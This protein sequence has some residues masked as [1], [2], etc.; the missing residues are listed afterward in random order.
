MATSTEDTESPKDWEHGIQLLTEAL[1]KV[2][3]D[4]EFDIPSDRAQKSRLC[5]HKLLQWV[6]INEVTAG[7]FVMD[8]LHSLQRCCSHPRPVKF[9]TL[10]E[11]IWENYY[12]HRS[13][14]EFKRKWISFI[15]SAIGFQPNAILYQF[16]TDEMMASVMKDIFPVLNESSVTPKS[17]DYAEVNALRYTAG[18][19]PRALKKK[20]HRSGNPLKVQLLGCLKEIMEGRFIFMQP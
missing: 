18:Y 10:K 4:K 17:L 8:L 20:I 11:R 3:T 15:M 14:G 5:A 2:L 1:S 16:L 7:P 19:V 6:R 9:H 13:S 12:K